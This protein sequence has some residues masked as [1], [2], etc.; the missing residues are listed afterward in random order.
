MMEQHKLQRRAW[1]RKKKDDH[2]AHEQDCTAL[3]CAKSGQSACVT[4]LIGDAHE[5]ARLRDLGLREGARVTVLRDGDPLMVKIESA[6]FGIGRAAAM[7]V[8]CDLDED[9]HS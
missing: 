4:Q 3:C 6:R 5:A 1:F 9:E 2:A 7:N 8:L